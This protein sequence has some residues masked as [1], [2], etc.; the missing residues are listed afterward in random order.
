MAKSSIKLDK[1]PNRK[2]VKLTLTLEPEIYD[3]LKDYARIYAEEYGDDEP[4]QIIAAYMIND[5]M[6]S[7]TAFKRRRKIGENTAEPLK[8]GAIRS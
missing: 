4:V 5:F 1:L 2:P 8:N 7:D 3:A 6:D